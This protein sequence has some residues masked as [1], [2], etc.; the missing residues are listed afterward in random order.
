MKHVIS[1]ILC[2]SIIAMIAIIII[3]TYY[4]EMSSSSWLGSSK[5]GN[6]VQTISALA[7]VLALIAFIVDYC[8]SC[9]LDS[10]DKITHGYNWIE[11][12]KFMA[13]QY[14]YLIRLYREMTPKNPMWTQL[15][16]NS[17]QIDDQVKQRVLEAHVCSW[18]FQT[19]EN[20]IG[21]GNGTQD[22]LSSFSIKF[23]ELIRT[24]KVWFQSG[25]IRQQWEAM[26]Y[27]YNQQTNQLVQKLL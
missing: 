3:I 16:D 4:F 6:Y 11:L 12:E 25:I 1:W 20:F 14:P 24:W 9:G 10:N 7:V 22:D 21:V 2:L 19:L 13:S 5:F 15:H 26:K 23:P 27:Q 8:K 18:I 17:F